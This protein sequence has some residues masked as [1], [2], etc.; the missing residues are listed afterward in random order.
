RAGHAAKAVDLSLEKRL[1]AASPLS[2][3]RADRTHT[4]KLTEAANYTWKLD[5][6]VFGEHEALKVS[7]GE[8]MEITFADDT[9][10]AHPMHLHG[11]HFQV[12]AIDGERFAG[13]MRD[14]VL[15]PAQGSV[16]IAFDAGNPGR[17]ALHCHHL[18]HMA[19]G[20]MTALHYEDV[21]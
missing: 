17:W 1:R 13:A 3:R 12:V 20:M 18:Y 19:G 15:V 6:A 5:G 14:T 7:E 21:A 11:H 8:R 4:M 2:E 16:T 10:M 9:T